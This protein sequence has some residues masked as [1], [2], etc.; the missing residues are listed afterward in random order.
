MSG[1]F[2]AAMRRLFW[3]LVGILIV[4][5]WM[6][7]AARAETCSDGVCT[8]PATV[9]STVAAYH[10]FKT[11][12]GVIGPGYEAA[13]AGDYARLC[14]TKPP[15]GTL[16]AEPTNLAN[17]A[18]FSTGQY[19]VIGGSNYN[20]TVI[21]FA[22]CSTS[23]GGPGGTLSGGAGSYMCTTPG[24][25]CPS[26]G[27]WTLSGTNCT[28]PACASGTT[29]QTDG[30]CL[31]NC[32]VPEND[33]VD[34]GGVYEITSHGAEVSD[35][36]NGCR[37]YIGGKTFKEGART[38]GQAWSY[39]T[40]CTPGT[41]V[42]GVEAT[43]EE[44]ACAKRGLCG[45]TLNGKQVCTAC[46]QTSQTT[47][48][49]KTETPDGGGPAV[50]TTTTITEVCKESGSCTTTTTSSSSAGGS[51]TTTT[52]APGG[53]ASG[54]GT[55]P[56][57]TGNCDTDASAIE[58]ANSAYESAVCSAAP[59][60]TGDAVQCA[61]ALE[62]WKTRCDILKA[63][64]PDV[65]DDAPIKEADATPESKTAY[66][67]QLDTIKKQVTGELP[68]PSADSKSAWESA[69][70]SGWF[71]AITITGCTAVDYAIGP[72]VWHFDPCPTAE[73]ISEIGSY[74]LWM[75]LLIGGFVFLTGGRNAGMSH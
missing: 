11:G 7:P 13:A 36:V 58:C 23:L 52:T 6:V 66:E 31:E 40:P 54:E 55:T 73:K 68:D 26:T 25:Y 2:Q 60:C 70:S 56:D 41:T 64:T 8:Q 62:V 14:G 46:D 43:P 32:N 17:A 30:S 50:T 49:T 12:A 9:G 39:G 27:G 59:T 10:Y 74:A 16:A 33:Q 20:A 61:Q 19:C 15:S 47:K 29:R 4:S 45:G 35:C 65:A 28:R 38:Y 24:Y 69:L 67:E 71:D 42:P 75:T 53:T 51:S 63:I 57:A 5:V 72:Y 18:Y 48:T 21:H 37:V 22:T 44:E 3:F 34:A 1:D